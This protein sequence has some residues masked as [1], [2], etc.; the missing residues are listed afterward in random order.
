M[1]ALRINLRGVNAAARRAEVAAF[2]GLERAVTQIAERV[3]SEARDGHT[4]TNRSGD[5]EQSIRAID[6]YTGLDGV[7]TGGV[8]A[9]EDYA[10]HVEAR[11]GFAFLEPAWERVE[12]EADAMIDRALSDAVART[13]W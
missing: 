6:T 13:N 10:E 4:F 7:I 9:D 1:P 5:L 11:A 12:P 8:I 3:A 2:A